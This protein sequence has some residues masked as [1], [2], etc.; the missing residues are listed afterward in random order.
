[1]AYNK[2][3][4]HRDVRRGW[5]VFWLS[6]KKFIKDEWQNSFNPFKCLWSCFTM[7][8]KLGFLLIFKLP[9]FCL[10]LALRV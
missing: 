9:F 10:R 1:M 8:A 3:R 4:F 7:V 5:G 6:A 2:V